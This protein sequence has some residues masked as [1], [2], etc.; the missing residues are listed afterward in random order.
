VAAPL[1]LTATVTDGGLPLPRKA[2][3]KLAF[4][5]GDTP[6]TGEPA[7]NRVEFSEGATRHGAYGAPQGLRLSWIV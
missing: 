1:V 5:P 4:G 2:P 7:G 3:R 6:S